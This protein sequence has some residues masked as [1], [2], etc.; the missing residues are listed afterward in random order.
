MLIDTNELSSYRIS[1]ML[2]QNDIE[3][4]NIIHAYNLQ[5]KCPLQL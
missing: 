1:S 3:Q 2:E 5:P 4:N